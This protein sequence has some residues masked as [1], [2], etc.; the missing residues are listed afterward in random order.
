MILEQHRYMRYV[1][2]WRS[3]AAQEIH[4]TTPVLYVDSRRQVAL[5]KHRGRGF[6]NLVPRDLP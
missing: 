3:A 5:G 6:F 2:A 1:H 4:A